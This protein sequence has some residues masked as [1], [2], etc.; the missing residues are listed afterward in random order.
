MA[1]TT[2]TTGTTAGTTG[3][4]TTSTGLMQRTAA[5]HQSTDLVQASANHVVGF[6]SRVHLAPQAAVRFTHLAKLRFSD[7]LGTS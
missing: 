2:T 1:S 7:L 3:N 5:L 4:G 6:E